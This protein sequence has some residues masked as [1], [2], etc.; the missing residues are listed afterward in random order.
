MEKGH[1]ELGEILFVALLIIGLAAAVFVFT[2]QKPVYLS[3]PGNATETDA[4]QPPSEEKSLASNSTNASQPLSQ[5][6]GGPLP[7]VNATIGSILEDGLTRGDSRFYSGVVSGQYDIDT[8]KWMMGEQNDT[9]D[10]I[11][12]KPNDLRA[13][14]VRFNGSYVDSLRG[15]AFKVY[16]SPTFSKPPKIYGMAVFIS[17][18]NPLK[19][20]NSTFKVYYD[21]HPEGTQILEGCSVLSAS[22]YETVGGSPL[23]V[24]DIECKIMYGANP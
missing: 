21:P 16:S 1:I 18:I 15:F 11:P 20:T 24:Y 19:G 22:E 3:E 4:G 10:S 7:V 23:E 5:P 17:D 8:Y 9:P 2:G 12:L 13:I 6:E 14:D